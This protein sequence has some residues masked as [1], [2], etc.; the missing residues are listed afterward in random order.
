[1]NE[2]GKHTRIKEAIH[3]YLLNEKEPRTMKEI[4]TYLISKYKNAPDYHVLSNLLGKNKF[5]FKKV[6]N[7]RV[8][9]MKGGNYNAILWTANEVC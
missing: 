6:G 3:Q 2:K 1:M 7:K 4:E 5:F 8:P 9:L